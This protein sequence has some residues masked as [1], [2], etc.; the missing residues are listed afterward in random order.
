MPGSVQK[1]RRELQTW[2]QRVRPVPLLE[3]ARRVYRGASSSKL[4]TTSQ[5]TFM[6]CFEN[7]VLKGWVTEK[8]FD[9]LVTGTIPI[10]WGAT[11]VDTFVPADCFIDMRHFEG[12]GELRSYL[13]SLDRKSIE[14]YRENGRA[15][16]SSPQFRPFTKQ[17]FV[18]IMARLVEEDAGV[19]L[20]DAPQFSAVS[21]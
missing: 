5:Y 13:K 9:C 4:E 19:E 8:I 7:V 2:W 3:A 17:A 20:R 1:V 16:L 21:R 14:C 15:Y 11:D 10:Y 18:D 6:L 12:Y